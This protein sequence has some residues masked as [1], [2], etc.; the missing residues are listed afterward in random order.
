M[1]TLSTLYR[2]RAR[3]GLAA[4]ETGDDF[5]LTTALEAASVQIERAAG[6]HF[7]PRRAAAWIC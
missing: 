7:S 2:L 6:R 4:T 3:L 1:Y 5:R